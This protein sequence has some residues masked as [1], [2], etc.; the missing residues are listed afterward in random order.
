M[1]Q[2][3]DAVKVFMSLSSSSAGGRKVR[4]PNG[5]GA[6]RSSQRRVMT[7]CVRRASHESK[8]VANIHESRRRSEA[9]NQ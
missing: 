2:D 7:L 4:V 1:V 6:T 5:Q 3:E 9:S 8:L